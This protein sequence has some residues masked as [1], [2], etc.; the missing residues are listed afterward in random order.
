MIVT[1]TIQVMAAAAAADAAAADAAS[2]NAFPPGVADVFVTAGAATAPGPLLLPPQHH[3]LLRPGLW[4]SWRL[5]RTRTAAAADAQAQLQGAHRGKLMLYHT[6]H[7]VDS[8][9]L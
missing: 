5:A 2:D 4:S 8:E 6:N 9:S 3:E 1:P 7:T